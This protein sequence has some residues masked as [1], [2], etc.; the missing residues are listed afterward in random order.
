M[1][2]WRKKYEYLHTI[3]KAEKLHF[4]IGIRVG[5][6]WLHSC[7]GNYFK[8][9]VDVATRHDHGTL[10]PSEEVSLPKSVTYR[11]G[12]NSIYS[13][14]YLC[15]EKNTMHTC[16]QCVC[17]CVCVSIL[18]IHT[19][20][21]SCHQPTHSL[22]NDADIY[23]WEWLGFL[24]QQ[25]PECSTK[26]GNWFSLNQSTQSTSH[27]SLHMMYQGKNN[28]LVGLKL[29]SHLHGRIRRQHVFPRGQNKAIRPKYLSQDSLRKWF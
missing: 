21:L 7:L 11:N 25:A 10:W 9:N 26:W 24:S 5:V 6:W 2:F 14:S 13:T 20:S 3:P 28:Q 18:G 16:R 15:C 8:G 27:C 12:N 17:V 22:H 1:A 23:T 4:G 19:D 29:L